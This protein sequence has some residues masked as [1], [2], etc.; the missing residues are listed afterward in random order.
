MSLKR[1]SEELAARGMLEHPAIVA[2]Y[3]QYTGAAT[4]IHAGEYLVPAGTTPR[5]LLDQLT[6]GAVYLHELTVVE[7]WR[8]AEFLRALR[9]HPAIVPAELSAEEIMA[10][11][12]EP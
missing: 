8:F 4:R 12:G 9:A 1:L 7:G 2:W 3:G 11:L 6:A 10:A 5:T